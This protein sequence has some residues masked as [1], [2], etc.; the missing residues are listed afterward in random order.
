MFVYPVRPD[1]ALPTWIDA[2]TAGALTMEPGRIDANR[3]RWLAEWTQ[4]VL[5]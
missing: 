3:D 1:A 2:P 5:R 4:L